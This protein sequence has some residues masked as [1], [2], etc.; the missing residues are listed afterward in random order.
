MKL[1]SAFFLSLFAATA[2][3]SCVVPGDLSYGPGYSSASVGY[4]QYNTLPS[5][6]VG[7]AYLYGGRYYS[8]GR[9]ENGSFFDQGRSYNDLYYYNGQ[10][11]YGGTHQHYGSRPTTSHRSNQPYSRIKTNVMVPTTHSSHS[12][13]VRSPF[14]YRR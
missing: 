7:S 13:T 4:R 11:Y 5:G 9:Y 12:T 2:M 6:Y 1:T 8:G 10:Y 3:T 14:L